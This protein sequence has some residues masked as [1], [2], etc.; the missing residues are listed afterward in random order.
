MTS[1]SVAQ[2]GSR[3][4][5]KPLSATGMFAAKL[6]SA[7]ATYLD[8]TPDTGV[9]YPTGPV[10]VLSRAS[11]QAGRLCCMNLQGS[12]NDTFCPIET[13]LFSTKIK[14]KHHHLQVA[15]L[16]CTMHPDP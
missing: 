1:L 13:W 8:L 12:L 14:G 6:V 9:L 2:D 16:R 10:T 7:S 15:M 5:S 3:P 11:W 4:L